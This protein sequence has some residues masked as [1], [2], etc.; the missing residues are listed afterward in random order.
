MNNLMTIL[1]IIVIAIVIIFTAILT[2]Q[3]ID[4]SREH[5]KLTTHPVR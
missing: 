1:K 4:Y 3:F 5:Y 2:T